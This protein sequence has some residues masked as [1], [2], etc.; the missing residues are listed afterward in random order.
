MLEDVLRD[1]DLGGL[2]RRVFR[3]GEAVISAD[4]STDLAFMLEKGKV[5]GAGPGGGFGPGEVMSPIEFLGSDFYET[6]VVALGPCN[7][8]CIPREM[9]RAAMDKGS[10]VTWL[11]SRSLAAEALMAQRT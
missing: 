7:V 9:V 5:R 10:P 1:V 11:L 6:P 3:K 8:I 2:A 4:T